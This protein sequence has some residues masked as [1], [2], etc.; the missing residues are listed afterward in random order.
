MLTVEDW[1]YTY[2]SLMA[3]SQI[4][5]YVDDTTELKNILPILHS[6]L[7]SQYPMVRFAACHAIGQI[8]DDLRSEFQ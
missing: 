4:G 6:R 2:A 3:L 7:S 5:E 1:R 8:S